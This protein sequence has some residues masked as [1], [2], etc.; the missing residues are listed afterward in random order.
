MWSKLEDILEE[1]NEKTTHNYW[2]LVIWSFLDDFKKLVDNSLFDEVND[3]DLEKFIRICDNRLDRAK[4]YLNDV[5]IVLGFAFASLSIVLTL[6]IVGDKLP[7]L[8]PDLSI[9]LFVVSLFLIL[10]G[11]LALLGHYRSQVHAWTVFKERAILMK[12]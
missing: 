9:I 5:A 8:V 10:I 1:C 2:N 7:F 3:D 12:G 11:L 4:T 6:A